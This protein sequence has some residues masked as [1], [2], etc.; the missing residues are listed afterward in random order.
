[1]I[2][3]ELFRSVGGFDEVYLEECQDIDLCLKVRRS[4]S[5]VIY[6]P[7][8]CIYH[9][10]NGTRTLRES[11]QDRGVF[12]ERWG[13]YI[14]ESIFSA[15]EQS[16]VW[17]PQICITSYGGERV[18]WASFIKPGVLPLPAITFKGIEPYE[19]PENV[20]MR[21]VIPA[22]YEDPVKYDFVT[23]VSKSSSRS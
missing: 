5:A 17:H 13:A 11:G 9:F 20:R 18:G 21:R 7:Q 22:D 19:L 4:G 14:S 2:R 23:S 10:E 3:N 16:E 15:R 8:A 12:R 1:M 6:L